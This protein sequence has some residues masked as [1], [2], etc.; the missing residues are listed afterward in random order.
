MSPRIAAPALALI[1]TLS[2]V[3]TVDAHCEVP[4]GIYGDKARIDALYEDVATVEKAMQQIVALSGKTDALSVNQCVRWIQT[5]EEHAKKIQN[6]AWQYFMTQRVKFSEEDPKK[7]AKSLEQLKLLHGILQS[8]MKSKQTV[9]TAHPK[10]LRQL[11]DSFAASYFDAKDL[12]HIRKE[13]GKH[14]E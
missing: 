14:A 4:C 1:L 5:K 7:N 9:D 13:H 6:T 3:S 2:A 12:E 11:I 8:A 10:R